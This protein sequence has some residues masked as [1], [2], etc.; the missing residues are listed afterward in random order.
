[1]HWWS[2]YGTFDADES[3]QYPLPGQVIA[4][5]RQLSGLAR[6]EVALRLGIGSK[7]LYYA[8]K[9]GRG[10]DSVDR[11]RRLYTLL[12]IPPALL[13][14]CDV[15]GPAGWWL[16]EY[17]PFPAGL[18]GW[19]DPG[20]VVKY[21]RRAKQWTQAAL[22]SALGIEEL[23][24]RKMENNNSGLD[25]LKRRRALRF[26]LTVPSVLFGLNGLHTANAATALLCSAPA[27]VQPS[28]EELRSAQQRLW[29]GYYDGLD[30]IPSIGFSLSGLKDALLSLSGADRSAYIEQVSLLYQAAGNIQLASA[31]TRQVLNSMDKGIKY[32]RLSE[33]AGLLSTALG[34]RAAALW[35]LGEQEAAEKSIKEA[36]FVASPGEGVKR[37]PVAS[38]VLSCSAQD[39]A[40]RAEVYRM[41]DSIVE[42]DRYQN[43]VDSNII[44][45]C[46]AQVLNNL[47]ENSSES[48]R[49]WG[50]AQELLDR[51]D[52]SAPDTTRRHLIIRLEQARAYLG[53]REYD[54]AA[55]AAIEAFQLMR[56]LKSVL[57]LPQLMRIY[58]A[59]L[60]S[61]YA[62]SP[63]VGRLGL[64]LFQAG[65]YSH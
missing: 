9:E 29:A 53:L 11:L 31:N 39:R 58:Q 55:A 33:D 47:A 19:P 13:G 40:E 38:R 21:Y 52:R 22:A 32:A 2:P 65:A 43:G 61:S 18:D 56:Q 27:P 57:Y 44:L 37:Y 8:E 63:Q 3:G 34:R 35:E 14:L 49:L 26:L 6:E 41:L 45:W 28:L 48:R 12:E 25:S 17:E 20:A 23:M 50:Q 15:P 54:Y 30:E 59:L 5:Y 36:L 1:M 60:Q 4:H 42:N 24:V 10:L 51:A 7:A 62:S 64:L 46:R 16:D